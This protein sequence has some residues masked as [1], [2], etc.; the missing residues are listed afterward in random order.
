MRFIDSH[1]HLA[2]YE[3]P[4]ALLRYALASETLLVTTS[5]D[6]ETSSSSLTLGRRHPEIVRPFVGI[7]P[8]EAKRGS[9]ID[10]LEE[11]LTLA[12]GVGEIGLDPRYSE[13]SAGSQ[14]MGIFTAQLELS[15]KT[16]KPVQVHTRG[17]EGICVDRLQSYKP[18]KVLLHWF[19]GEEIASRAATSGYY[20]SFGPALLYS[21]KLERIAA[22]YPEDLILSES[23]GPVAFA[24]LGGAGGSL[25]VPS[26]IFRLAQLR[27]R[28]FPEM[29][30]IVLR[31]GLTYLGEGRKVRDSN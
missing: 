30:D 11:A 25:L 24:A 2:G 13:V 20:V 22:G 5:V 15:E 8:S 27:G 19:E 9:K 18:A 28:C 16:V 14:Q 26:V 1:V 4:G 29:A 10:W 12:S 6:E 23:D 31:N 3:Q 21:K 7:H 17:A